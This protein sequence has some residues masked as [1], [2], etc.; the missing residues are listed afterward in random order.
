M[1]YRDANG[2]EHESYADACRYYGADTPEQVE[3][4]QMYVYHEELI[5]NQDDLEIYGGPENLPYREYHF[6][7]SGELSDEIPF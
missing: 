2:I 3:S 6:S 7:A 1:I 5:I 4:E